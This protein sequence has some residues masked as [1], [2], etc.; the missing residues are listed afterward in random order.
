[1]NSLD[2]FQNAAALCITD[3]DITSSEYES[4]VVEQI[5]KTLKETLRANNVV[6]R[7]KGLPSL[8]K[9]PKI[10]SV[11]DE[12]EYE[13]ELYA[14]LSYALAAKMLIAEGRMRSLAYY[15]N[16]NYINLTTAIIETEEQ[17]KREERKKFTKKKS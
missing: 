10:T 12:I 3:A 1:M 11:G 17:Q 2:I 16:R 13:I 7:R 4:F 6:R 8:R 14:P 9:V 5:N 15:Y